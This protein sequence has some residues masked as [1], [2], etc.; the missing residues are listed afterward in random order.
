MQEFLDIAFSF[1]TVAYTVLLAVAVVVATLMIVGGIGFEVLE[2]D[3]DIDGAGVEEAG[4]SVFQMLSPFGLG[5]VPMSIFGTTFVFAGW[6]LCF[7]FVFGVQ[8]YIMD[9]NWMIGSLLLVGATVFAFPITGLLMAPLQ[10]LTA[11]ESGSRTGEHLIGQVCEVSTSRV[12]DGFGRANVYIEGSEL[13][14]SI[15]CPHDNDLSRGDRALILGFNDRDNLYEVEPFDAVLGQQVT[16]QSESQKI[17]L[18]DIDF[19]DLEE[20]AEEHEEQKAKVKH[21]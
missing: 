21:G 20:A 15:R 2:L 16:P 3:F 7:L 5:A 13:I 1:P 8:E 4:S 10:A 12:D 14:L 6:S 17:V 9:V 19:E 11:G 18:E